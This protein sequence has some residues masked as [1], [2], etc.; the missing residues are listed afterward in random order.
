MPETNSTNDLRS[1]NNNTQFARTRGSLCLSPVT[2]PSVVDYKRKS[3]C[4]T[5][6]SQLHSK[7][8]GEL[9]NI[10]MR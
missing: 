4:G 10:K 2:S 5:P 9:A 6:T 8:Y 1:P 7:R 3:W